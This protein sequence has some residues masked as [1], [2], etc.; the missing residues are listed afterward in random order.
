MNVVAFEAIDEVNK[1]ETKLTRKR[2]HLRTFKSPETEPGPQYNNYYNTK[3][4][5]S[6]RNQQLVIQLNFNYIFDGLLA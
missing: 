4:M 2:C 1:M 3:V 5:Q 6:S